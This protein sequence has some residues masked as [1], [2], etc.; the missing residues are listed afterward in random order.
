VDAAITAWTCQHQDDA[1]MRQ[2]Q[3][4]GVPAGPSLDIVRVYHDPHLRASGYFTPLQTSDGATRDLP[5]LPW[6]FVGLEPPHITAA[7]VLGQSTGSATTT[8]TIDSPTEGT[9]VMN[10]TQVVVGGWAVDTA[11]PGTGIEAVRIYLDNRMDAGGTLLGEATY[12]KSR[13]DVATTL[14]NSAFANSGFDYLWTPRGLSAGSHRLYV[15]ARSRSGAWSHSTVGVTVRTQSGMLPEMA[16]PPYGDPYGYPGGYR[17]GLY[18]P[19]PG[20]WY[21]YPRYPY[22]PGYPNYPRPPSGGVCI[23]IYPPPPGC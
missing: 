16:G 11:G 6:R 2:L 22:N 23:M 13:P 21:P 7:P 8:I 10:G 14:G 15:H 4:A 18:P 5:G 1:A 12:G 20:G 3:A 17:P 19:P 9:T